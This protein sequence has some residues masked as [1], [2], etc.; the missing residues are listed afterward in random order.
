MGILER[1]SDIMKSNINALLDK[2]EDPAKMIDQLLRDLSE[3]LAEVKDKTA[4]VMANE[5]R[6]LRAVDDCKAEIQKMATSAQNALKA[7]QEDDARK[8]IQRKQELEAKLPGLESNAAA[9]KKSADQMRQMHD[10]LV[11]DINE[12]NN[13][14]DTIKAKVANAQ[15]QET[16][17]KMQDKMKTGSRAAS[18]F[19]RMEEKAD[20]M[21]DEALAK[22]EL[23]D[24]SDDTDELAEKY[25]SGV[26]SS[27][28]DDELEKM[29]QQLGL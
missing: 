16:V 5:K 6:D 1:F 9:S 28:V 7:G 8:L 12:L 21:L 11:N 2:A 3:S 23:N 24:R 27:S 4:A 20:K 22:A 18:A 17:N 13:R 26:N 19:A 29:K 14:K 25:A 15:A 10:K